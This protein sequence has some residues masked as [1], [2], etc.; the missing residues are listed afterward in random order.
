MNDDDDM[1]VSSIFDD[2]DDDDDMYVSSLF[3]DDDDD[4]DDMF[5][6]SFFDDDDDEEYLRA[7]KLRRS[8]GSRSE[9]RILM[10]SILL[11]LLLAR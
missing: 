5:V 10:Y 7:R 6:S 9:E 3:D 8:Y 1:Y 4:D 2:D 11:N